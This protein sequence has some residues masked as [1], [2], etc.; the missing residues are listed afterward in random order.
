MSQVPP[1]PPSLVSAEAH[2]QE[3][4]MSVVGLIGLI[5]A[6]PALLLAFLGP[7]AFLSWFFGLPAF[8]L[9]LMGVFKKSDK[10]GLPFAA[11]IVSVV[12]FIISIVVLIIAI[13]TAADEVDSTIDA[14]E[15]IE[16]P[17]EEP[18]SET[19][20]PDD[21]DDAD[22]TDAGE[23]GTPDS[24]LA[25]GVAWE[26][27]T[28]WFGEDSV[29]WEGTVEGLVALETDEFFGDPG[30]CY[31]ILG[32]LTPTALPEGQFTASWIETPTF[33]AYVGGTA[34]GEYGFCNTDGLEAAGYNQLLDLEVTEG[35]PYPYF[36][37]VFLPEDVN[38][39]IDLIVAVNF[40]E[41][42]NVY[43]A[44]DPITVP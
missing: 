16:F 13:A 20:G 21:G 15:D 18:G 23:R 34:Q 22:A 38:G 3:K 7:L 25:S 2:F 43:L 35:T 17:T 8:V 32:V 39:D 41:E 37:I 40:D 9:G 6:G 24:P 26:F 36:D 30:R 11:V 44:A 12:A 10:S 19:E 33:Q 27:D 1:P 31:A 14:L 28:S 42:Y 29:V 5:L 4:K